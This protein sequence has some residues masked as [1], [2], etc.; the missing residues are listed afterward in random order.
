MAYGDNAQRGC[1][2][3]TYFDSKGNE[4]ANVNV[5]VP[6]ERHRLAREHTMDTGESMAQLVTRLLRQELEG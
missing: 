3:R 6:V 1:A 2:V 5:R 4:L